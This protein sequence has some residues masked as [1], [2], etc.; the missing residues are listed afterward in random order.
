MASCAPSAAA[1]RR[2]QRKCPISSGIDGIERWA[3]F[4]LPTLQSR[5]GGSAQLVEEADQR[6]ALPCIERRQRFPG[7]R[8]RIGRCLFGQLLPSTSEAYQ[9]AAAVLGIRTGLGQ[10]A[11]GEAVDHALDGGGI[12]RRQPPELVL[13]TRPGFV[14]LGKRRPLRRR[15]VDADIAREDRSVPLPYLAQDET[16][17][18]VEDVGRPRRLDAPFQRNAPAHACPP[19]L[20]TM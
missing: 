8:Q 15:Q 5:G 11:C 18:L 14:Q 20:A 16:D 7:Y 4:A 1:T 6:L 12:H 9:K 3:R 13:R 2:R 10:A 17:L 19:A